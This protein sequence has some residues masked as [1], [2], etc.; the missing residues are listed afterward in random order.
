MT[1]QRCEFSGCDRPRRT[2]GWC[3]THY[4]QLRNG[5]TMHPIGERPHCGDDAFWSKIEVTGFCWLWT[6]PL[7]IRGAYGMTSID[8]QD[9]YAH[10]Y[11]YERLLGAIPEGLVLDHLCR[12]HHC[13]NPDHLEPVTIGE[14]VRRGYREF[15]TECI[16]GHP[17]SG[18]NLYVHPRGNRVCRAC[19]RVSQR[20]YKAKIR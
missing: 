9:V 12:V 5:R 3:S 2:R 13:V 1:Q 18:D 16:N 6:G 14:N 10:R 15:K 4:E 20:K 19:R 8:G 7:N 11:A 17:F